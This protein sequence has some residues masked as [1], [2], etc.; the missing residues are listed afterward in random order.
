MEFVLNLWLNQIP[1]YTVL[2]TQL[3]LINA[4]ID[5]VNGPAIAAALATG[6]IKKFEIITGGLMILNLPMSYI[7]LFWGCAPEVTMIVSIVLS[8]V[9]I[10]IRSFI[11][12][13]LMGYKVVDYMANVFFPLLM[14]GLLSFIFV[15]F[16]GKCIPNAVIHF[17]VTS[18]VAVLLLSIF[19]FFI[20][21][22]SSERS[23]TK[24]YILRGVDKLFH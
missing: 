10:I 5:S 15:Y 9:T 6:R 20:A 22:T 17:F 21:L 14:I 2:F 16:I 3:V 11:L 19:T 23:T 7:L 13:K 24:K 1:D 12:E 4:L 18:I 8:L